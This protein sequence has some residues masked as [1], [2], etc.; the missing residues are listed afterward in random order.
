MRYFTYLAEQSFK[1]GP[2]GERLFFQ[3]GPWSRP[4]VIPNAETERRIYQKVVWQH[5]I[6][7]GLFIVTI[8]FLFFFIGVPD[9]VARPAWPAGVI[10]AGTAISWL[11]GRLLL[12][13]DIA[14][15]V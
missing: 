10:A 13:S 2:N 14:G 6:N 15:L 5:R 12:G 7:V 1:A 3:S 4:Y 11:A 9:L 8:V